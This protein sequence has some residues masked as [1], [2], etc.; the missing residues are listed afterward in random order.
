MMIL[1]PLLTR[2]VNCYLYPQPLDSIFIGFQLRRI[3]RAVWSSPQRR[4]AWFRQVE[5]D[6]AST[7]ASA[8]NP[9]NLSP[10][11]GGGID[12]AQAINELDEYFKVVSRRL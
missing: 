4:Q 6:G 8:Q 10:D 12:R 5:S 11:M 2:Q 1:F 9:F 3:I 7:N